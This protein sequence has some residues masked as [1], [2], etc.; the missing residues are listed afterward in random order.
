MQITVS[1]SL[2]FLESSNRSKDTKSPVMFFWLLITMC[3]SLGIGYLSSERI[4]GHQFVFQ[5]QRMQLIMNIPPLGKRSLILQMS[6][7][8]ITAIRRARA[9]MARVE[10]RQIT[11]VEVSLVLIKRV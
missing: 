6:S 1:Y 8:T 3:H 4:Q 10:R 11:T 5:Y 7:P 2:R 9:V